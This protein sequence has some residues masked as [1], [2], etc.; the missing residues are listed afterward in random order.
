MHD[1]GMFSRRLKRKLMR[2]IPDLEYLPGELEFERRYK[3]LNP[4][5]KL[6][7]GVAKRKRIVQN[8]IVKS[9][10]HRA[11]TRRVHNNADGSVQHY[12]EEKHATAHSHVFVERRKRITPATYRQLLRLR[13]HKYE[14]VDKTR[15]H[16]RKDGVRYDLDIFHAGKPAHKAHRLELEYSD[17]LHLSEQ[18]CIPPGFE[19]EEITSPPAQDLPQ[20]LLAFLASLHHSPL[21]LR[22]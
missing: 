12:Y 21:Q 13:D 8:F 14:E 1:E 10:K 3:W 7:P 15:Y 4:D 9:K 11:R 20:D 2:L 6:I 22:R 18:P 5:P 16:W 19:V 17:F